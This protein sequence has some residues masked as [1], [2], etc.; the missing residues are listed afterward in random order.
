MAQRV[1]GDHFELPADAVELL[2]QGLLGGGAEQHDHKVRPS[3]LLALRREPGSQR[4]VRSA[5]ADCLSSRSA[6][7]VRS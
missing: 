5:W 6:A 1:D 3:L 2:R 7:A 4:G